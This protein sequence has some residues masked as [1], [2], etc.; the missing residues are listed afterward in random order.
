MYVPIMC[1]LCADETEAV[2][3]RWL[4]IDSYAHAGGLETGFMR[5]NGI[6]R[7]CTRW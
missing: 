1:Q 3:G 2:L 5:R 6:T 4:G 7:Q